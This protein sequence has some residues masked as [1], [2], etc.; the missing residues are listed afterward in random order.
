MLFNSNIY[1]VS[2]LTYFKKM[3]KDVKALK[4]KQFECTE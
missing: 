4:L 3:Y 1:H 2:I